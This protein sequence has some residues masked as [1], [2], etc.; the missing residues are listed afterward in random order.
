MPMKWHKFQIY[1]AL[2]LNVVISVVSAF[3]A[4]T[5]MQ[6]G[7][8]ADRVYRTFDGL[9]EMDM[10]YGMLHLL[11]AVVAVVVRFRL[12]AMRRSGIKGLLAM[13]V[14]NVAVELLYAVV[15]GG[16]IG[17]VGEVL[18]EMAPSFVGAAAGFFINRAYYKNRE[19][20][21]S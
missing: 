21:F 19:V 13:Y 12:A 10:L 6:Y 9:K 18:G 11:C 15:V 2:W 7:E 5:G 14:L 20:M 16:M 8:M 1:F 17:V 4:F 3:S